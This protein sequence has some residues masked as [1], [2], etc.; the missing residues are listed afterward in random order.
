M[1]SLQALGALTG[2]LQ[3]MVRHDPVA[4]DRL[5]LM[6]VGSYGM[7]LVV[8]LWLA[9]HEL[10][11]ALHFVALDTLPFAAVTVFGGALLFYLL[12]LVVVVR[13][14]SPLT[15]IRRDIAFQRTH[16]HRSLPIAWLLLLMV[17][18]TAFFSA[19]K[20]MI[21]QLQPFRWDSTFAEVDRWMHGGTH[22]W[23]YTHAI[24]AGA[25]STWVINLIYHLWFFVMHF[26]VV[27]VAVHKG[28][29]HVRLQYLL[30]FFLSWIVAGTVIAVLFSSAGPCY[31]ER[32][33]GLTSPYWELMQRLEAQHQQLS[34]WALGVQELLW[35]NHLQG[36]PGVTSAIS[37]MPSMH[38]G[39]SVLLVLLARQLGSRR[40]VLCS[41]IFLVCILLGSVHL[42]WHYAVDGYAAILVIL[43]IWWIAGKVARHRLNTVHGKT[44]NQD[45]R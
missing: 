8:F 13:P 25:L 9:G 1:N 39:S 40:A 44:V 31:F 12:R 35:A 45:K 33:T 28:S 6:V 26:S 24:F 21:P 10:G 15:S 42:G 22:P 11:E 16:P 2:R 20:A 36:G 7:S 41:T 19:W 27:W 29:P 37:A 34:V 4:G 23:R 30:A 38:V 3:R 14:A 5:L 18:F 17:L 43:P 32:V